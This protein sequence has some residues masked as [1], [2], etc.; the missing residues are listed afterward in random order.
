MN[1]ISP[2]D[3]LNILAK[4][5]RIILIIPSILCSITIINVLFFSIPVYKAT[6]K[7]MH[8]GNAG[9]SQATGLASQF[10]ISLPIDN[11]KVFSSITV[12]S[13][14]SL[15]SVGIDLRS[16]TSPSSKLKSSILVSKLS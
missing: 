2:F 11:S 13:M 6:S 3:I 7:I 1:T 14:S 16:N 15:D 10:G 9:Y 4:Q 12:V 5:I 8:T